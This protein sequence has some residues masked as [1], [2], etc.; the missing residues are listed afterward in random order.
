MPPAGFKPFLYNYRSCTNRYTNSHVIHTQLCQFKEISDDDHSCTEW[1]SKVWFEKYATVL[2]EEEQFKYISCTAPDYVFS[3]FLLNR[4]RLNKLLTTCSRWCHSMSWEGLRKRVVDCWRRISCR[5]KYIP[6][7]PNIHKLNLTVFTNYL[8]W[9]QLCKPHHTNPISFFIE[10]NSYSWSA[11][12]RFSIIQISNIAKQ[13]N[14]RL[15]IVSLALC[16]P[17]YKKYVL[18]I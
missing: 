6:L 18:L 16:Q 12:S 1:S 5:E 14:I 17:K 10:I 7:Y 3:R 4:R 9:E 15:F 2:D 13:D 11:L 8:R